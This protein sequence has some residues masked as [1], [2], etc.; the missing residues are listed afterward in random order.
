MINR[1]HT[2]GF[3]LG[4]ASVFAIWAI[5]TVCRPRYELTAVPN[6]GVYLV[7]SSTG[8]VWIRTDLPDAWTSL[9]RP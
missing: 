9:G 4:V 3:I 7:N 2:I 1:S 8:E 6:K 5:V